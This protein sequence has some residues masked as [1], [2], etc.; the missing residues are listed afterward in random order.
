MEGERY[1]WG[2]GRTD[3]VVRTLSFAFLKQIP[4]LESDGVEI[5]EHGGEVHQFARE[6][7]LPAGLDHERPAL[8]ELGRFSRQRRVPRVVYKS[9]M[10]NAPLAQKTEV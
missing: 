2:P 6:L 4:H 7:D 1:G 10:I 3:A 5:G 8:R 9:T